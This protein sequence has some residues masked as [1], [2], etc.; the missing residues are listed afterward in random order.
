MCLIK[1]YYHSTLNLEAVFS[2]E[3][4]VSIHQ[5]EWRSNPEDNN[6]HSERRENAQLEKCLLS[7][8]QCSWREKRK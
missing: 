3:T 1:Y 4:V 7:H 2:T 8:H 5:I 6:S